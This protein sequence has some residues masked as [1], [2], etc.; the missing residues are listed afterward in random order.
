MYPSVNSSFE[1]EYLVI[2]YVIQLAHLWRTNG[3]QIVENIFFIII[4]MYAKK[5]S[6]VWDRE[7]TI[8]TERPP[9]VGEVIANCCG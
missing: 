4:I 1:F 5:T 7:R 2:E 6:M 9:L 3:A 8:S